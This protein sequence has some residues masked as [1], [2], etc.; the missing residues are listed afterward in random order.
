MLA[1]DENGNEISQTSAEPNESARP[2]RSS[3][4]IALSGMQRLVDDPDLRMSPEEAAGIMGSLWHESGGFK[5]L[6]EIKPVSGRGGFGWAQWTGPRRRQFE[7]FAKANGMDIR[8]D[9]TNFQ[10]LKHELL[11]TPEGK[12]LAPLKRA[13]S[14][15]QASDTFTNVFERPGVPALGS[16]RRNARKILSAW[17]NGGPMSDVPPTDAGMIGFSE[18]QV[19]LPQEPTTDEIRR[20]MPTQVAQPE[21]PPSLLQRGKNLL[22]DAGNAVEDFAYNQVMDPKSVVNNPGQTAKNLGSAAL[23]GVY[24]GSEGVLGTLQAGAE[25][26]NKYLTGPVF[27]AFGVQ[28]P[29]QQL[30][31]TYSKARQGQKTIAERLTPKA[32]S[33]LASGVYS[34]MQSI[35]Q[36]LMTIP[37]AVV[38]GNPLMALAPM[39]VMTGGQSYGEARDA[40]KSPERAALYGTTQGIIEVGTETIPMGKLLGS[41]KAND[42]LWKTF[43]KQ[44]VPE[45]LG[46]QA[47]TF[48]QDLDK[49]VELN[50]DKT[51]KEFMAER[52]SAAIQTA[53]ATLVGTGGQVL[54]GKAADAAAKRW[55]SENKIESLYNKNPMFMEILK[56][57][58]DPS[59]S[60]I[61]RA[62]QARDIM[63][64]R[65]AAAATMPAER[66][67]AEDTSISST[68][69][70]GDTNAQDPAGASTA[71]AEP[72]GTTQAPIQEGQSQ[73]VNAA[74]QAGLDDQ[75]IPPVAG[76]AAEVSPA[77]TVS[78][79]PG[80]A[81]ETV[82][83]GSPT[84]ESVAP[85]NPDQTTDTETVS[86][87]DQGYQLT[88]SASGIDIVSPEGQIHST[89]PD[90]ESALEA[91]EIPTPTTETTNEGQNQKA[92][93]GTSGQEGLLNLPG[94]APGSIPMP[95]GGQVIPGTMENLN[96]N[97]PTTGAG[98]IA[99]GTVAGSALAQGAEGGIAAGVADGRD[100]PASG[101]AG[102]NVGATA[103]AST[104]VN[105]V[106]EPALV[107]QNRNRSNPASVQ[108]M[109][110]IAGNPDYLRLSPSRNFADGAPVIAGGQ[111]PTVQ[112]GRKET[113]VTAKGRRIPVQYAVVEADSVLASNNADGTVN[114]AYGDTAIQAPRAI[115]G[116]GRIAGL[117]K[118][119][120]QGSAGQY[121]ADLAADDLH[122]ISPDIIKGMKAPVLVRVMPESE[123]TQ[124]IGDESNI[125]GGL[126]LSP[127]EQARN[128]AARLDLEG[129]DFDE[130]GTLGRAS[131][132]QFV[133]S[134]PESE[135]GGLL[136][137]DGTP[138]RQAHDRLNSAVF[139]KAYENDELVRL[140]TQ[141]VDPD[142]KLV[143]ST[144]SR[145]APKYS[146]LK[147][148]GLFDVRGWLTDAAK[149]IVNGRRRN[150]TMQQIADQQD[151]DIDP[152]A[153]DIIRLFADNPRSN[154]AVIEDLSDF[155]DFAYNEATR[156]TQ[157]MFGETPRAT[158]NDLR[159]RLEN[160]RE[161]RGQKDLAK[162]SRD[163]SVSQRAEEAAA[164]AAGPN[165][166][167]ETAGGEQG[168]FAGPTA[169]D[170]ARADREALA[171]A[172]KEQQRK[173]NA[174]QAP[175]ADDGL[176]AQDNRQDQLKFSLRPD[177]QQQRIRKLNRGIDAQN[178]RYAGGSESDARSRVEL[179]AAEDVPAARRI[180]W[181]LASAIAAVFKHNL[182]PVRG[183]NGGRL[184]FDAVVDPNGDPSSIFITVDSVSP[185]S[186]VVAHELLHGLRLNAPK[187]Y[188]NLVK[189]LRQLYDA[190]AL[191]DYVN[192]RDYAGELT[193]ANEEE[194]VADFVSNV[195]NS[196]DGLVRV[197][198]AMNRNKAGSGF[199][200]LRRVQGLV[201]RIKQGLA[202]T[203]LGANKV[204]AKSDLQK[205]EDAVVEAL[206]QYAAYQE[207][208]TQPSGKVRFSNRSKDQSGLDAN[209][210]N[211]WKGLAGAFYQYANAD[212]AL[213]FG[214]SDAKDIETVAK[215][216]GR[217]QVEAVDT[218]LNKFD[219]YV[220]GNK[221]AS[222][223][224]NPLQ[225]V[226]E[227]NTAQARS[228]G[229]GKAAMAVAFE[230]AHNNDYRVVPNGGLTTI[231]TFRWTESML[232]AAL[233]HGTT[234]HMRPVAEQKIRGWKQGDDIHNTGLLL[235]RS[236]ANV[237]E[238]IPS[239]EGAVFDLRSSQV[240]LPDGKAF[241]DEEINSRLGA[242]ARAR[243]RGIGLATAKK[244]LVIKAG[245]QG[246]QDPGRLAVLLVSPDEIASPRGLLYSNRQKA[247]KPAFSDSLVTLH[248]LTEENL[249]QA[250][251]IGG[252]PAPSL[253]ITKA[254]SPFTGFGEITLIGDRGLIDP[255][256]GT[257]VFDRDAWTSR[258]PE[259]KFKKIK[260]SKADAL[261]ERMKPARSM[262]DD[263][264][265]FTSD[266]FDRLRNDRNPSPDRVAEPFTRYLAP[267]MLYARDVLG[268][269]IKIPTRDYSPT[270]SVSAD[271]DVLAFYKANEDVIY[272]Q[273]DTS[274]ED[275]QKARDELARL[276]GQAIDRIAAGKSRPAAH[277]EA[278]RLNFFSENG[279]I[280]G[281]GLQVLGRDAP[282]IGTRIEDTIRLTKSIQKV[283][284]DNDPT[285]L[286]WVKEQ[287]SAL[288]DAPTITLRGRQVP[289]TLDNL[290]AAM[291]IG[292]TQGA[293]K[294][295]TFGSGKT[296]AHLGKQFQSIAEI[297]AARS[298]VVSEEEEADGR[299]LAQ[300]VLENYQQHV[301]QFYGGKDYRGQIDTWAGLNDAMEAL[302]KAGKLAD[303]DGNIRLSLQKKGFRKV[304]A[305]AISLARQAIKSLRDVTTNYF[306]AKPQRAVKLN[307]FSGAVAPKSLSPD[308]LEIL[309][310]NGLKVELYGKGDGAR[311]KAIAKLS[312]S[313][314]KTRGDVLFSNRPKQT[315]TPEFK[316]WFAGSKVVDENGDPLVVYHGSFKGADFNV[317]K[318]SKNGVV[319]RGIYL[320]PFNGN[321]LQYGESLYTLYAKVENPLI[322][323][324]ADIP[325]GVDMRARAEALGRDGIIVKSKMR[326]EEISELTVF[327]PNQIKSATDN[328][329]AFDPENDS[330]IQEP[331]QDD[332]FRKQLDIFLDSDPA[333]QPG[334]KTQA[335]RNAAVDAVDAL[336]GS[337]TVLGARL[338][339]TYAARQR[340]SLVG[341]T[342]T[343]R[344][345]LATLAQ[346]YRD[347]RFE[348]FRLFFTNQEGKI[349][350]QVGLTSRLPASSAV[351]VG[352]DTKKFMTDLAEA[353]SKA[354]ATHYYMLHNHPSTNP[355]PSDADV[356]MTQ[357]FDRELN[358]IS[359]GHVVID[360]NQFGFIKPSGDVE[361]IKKDFGQVSPYT[362]NEFSDT[363]ILNPESLIE[364]AKK[365]DV[366]QD[367]ITLVVTT[368]QNKVLGV[369][370]VPADTIRSG[371]RALRG[372]RIRKILKSMSGA[373][374]FA[375]GTHRPTLVLISNLVMD[376][377][378]I[379]ESGQYNS[380]VK[381][382]GAYGQAD[383]FEIRGRQIPRVTADTSPEFDY[384]RDQTLMARGGGM[385]SALNI[386][387]PKFSNRPNPTFYSQLARGFESSRMNSMP[388]SQW[389]AWLFSNKA[390]LGI[391][392]DE[393]AWT[394]IEDYLTLNAKEKLTKADIASYLADNGVRVEEVM[395]EEGDWAV[396]DGEDNQY[397]SSRSEAE[398]YAREIG[399]NIT[400][401]T[402][403]RGANRSGGYGTKFSTYTIPGGTNYRELLITLPT[404]QSGA[405]TEENVKPAQ[406]D[407][408]GGQPD[409]FWYFTVP[410]NF[411]QIRKSKY[412]NQADAKAYI[413]RE[414]QPEPT[415]DKTY[416]SSH[417][418]EKNVLAHIR[419]DERTDADGN[420]VMFITEL[421][422]DWGQEGKKKG[423]A[424]VRDFERKVAAFN[425]ALSAVGLRAEVS[426]QG[427]ATYFDSRGNRVWPSDMTPEEVAVVNAAESIRPTSSSIPAAPFVTDTKSWL[428]LGLKR[429][430]RYAAENGFDKIAFANG[431]QNADLYDL[432]KQV[433][434]IAVPMVNDDGSRSVRIDPEN[435]TAIKLMVDKSGV[436]DGVGPSSEQFTGKT[437]DDVVGKEIADRILSAKE[438][439]TFS[440]EGLKVGGE[441]MRKFY[442]QI[443]PQTANDVLKK[444]GG[445]RVGQVKIGGVT[446]EILDSV[447]QTDYDANYDDLS[448]R[449][450]RN[451]MAA[452]Q[453]KSKAQ[454][455]SQ[456]G[457]DITPALQ[458]KALDGMPLFSNRRNVINQ[459]ALA[460]WTT[461]DDSK[462]DNYV[463][464][465][466]DK[467]IDTKRIVEKL[468]SRVSDAWD[469]YLKETLYHGR[470]A[471]DVDDF[472]VNEIKPLLQAM[473]TRGITIGELETFLHNRHAKEANEQIARIN[474][475]YPDGGSGILTQDAQD[476]L[477][478]L[479]AGKR[480]DLE[481]MAAQI[482][483]IT[484]GTRR[485]LVESGLETQDTIDAWEATYADYVPLQRES[486][487]VLNRG[488][489][490]GQG[491]STKGPASKRRTG[492][493]KA[494][495]D[496]MANVMM[497][498]ERAITRAEKNKVG[499]ALY[500]LAIQNP[501]PEFWYPVNPDAVKKPASVAQELI[502][503]GMLESDLAGLI[504]EPTVASVNPR[505]GLVEYKINPALRNRDNVLAVR[506]KGKD[507][508]L[509]FSTENERAVRMAQS[510]K[511]LDAPE[512]HG[513][514]NAFRYITR[515]VS[516]INTQYN[517]I[518]GVVNLLRDTHGAMLNLSTTPIAGKQAE[519][520]AKIA[521]AMAGIY[522]DLRA[523]RK[524][525]P[526]KGSQ[527]SQLWEEF[528]TVG[529]KTGYRD[530]YATADD[531]MK[532]LEKE[533][534]AIQDG[535]VKRLTRGLFDWL[536]DYNETLE[537]AVR[538]SAYKVGTESGMSKEQAAV[539]AKELTVNF[540]RKGQIA[541]QAGSLYAFFNAAVQG[542]ARLAETVK[543]PAGKKIVAG[544]LLM[545]VIQAM[546]M[547]AAGYD[548]DEPPE[549]L[550]ERNFIIPMPN[551]RYV[552]IPMPL[553]FHVLP[554]TGR[555]LTEI[556]INPDGAGKKIA[557]LLGS[558]FEA[559]NP[560]G[561]AGWSVQTIA[562]TFADPLVALSE[563]RDAFGKEIAKKDRSSTSPTPGF[564]RTKDTA[565]WLSKQ[566]AWG[567]N[568][569][570]GGTD[571]TQG[572]LS[573]TPDQLDYVFSQATGGV[574]R[575]VMKIEQAASA[576]MTGEELP[577]YK[578]PLGV[579]R[580]IGDVKSQSAES[581]RFYANLTRL[582]ELEN[583][584]KGRA[585]DGKDVAG[586]L[587]SNPLATLVP[588][589]N[590]MERA[591]SELRS[592]KRKLI[593]QNAPKATIKALEGQ[594]A[595]Q[596][597]VLNDRV[598]AVAR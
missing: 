445:G 507:R 280:S 107:L 248:N 473:S 179:A 424:D 137:S 383:P 390:K 561:S 332:L 214:R 277:K 45:M 465:L 178:R 382:I 148:K 160:Y 306:E 154:K 497:Q 162:R 290:V 42:A 171:E 70:P 396:Y 429:A 566:L 581:N 421:Q 119:Y 560:I 342:L 29:V 454:S 95:A 221:V 38:T 564:T 482:D 532:A 173:S 261:Y 515:Y 528:Q 335:A 303:T 237:I 152:Q 535:K 97:D 559:F 393:I 533:L 93:A 140:H 537:N 526:R 351:I 438:P 196:P 305:E 358:L 419:F 341:H 407:P 229:S 28:D 79:V 63:A 139:Q 180:E 278:M 520:A 529:G 150:L 234:E 87:K 487:D 319:G 356:R 145:L 157:D 166:A 590:Q 439:T 226:A 328:T 480:T 477:A 285:Y 428:S 72:T 202:G 307:E 544:G 161:R 510:L 379:D 130:D 562:P 410:G 539:M 15:E 177:E 591:V 1:F 103:T 266:L 17:S 409:L 282:K 136:D 118:A 68:G 7:Q 434:S 235:A 444:L 488:M 48:L 415:P 502:N 227:V 586:F 233:R 155:A 355:M 26:T 571:Y 89:Y 302:A 334:P 362:A 55:S 370:T 579:G 492:S 188:D 455:M 542:T 144:L 464:L 181:K 289:P 592:R 417:W 498:R 85:G 314:E 395:K 275:G 81:V 13:R 425:A 213:Q 113:T 523:D 380:L 238:A 423:F 312:K 263:G 408:R 211:T 138:N 453:D 204:I 276:I 225:K 336:R 151:L 296:S 568:R 491:F 220:Q 239:L 367:A 12:V 483:A 293:E 470:A 472:K 201:E 377:L 549:F 511:N 191:V 524:G 132:L 283:V 158:Q 184:N 58:T 357:L 269:P 74:A 462:L 272:G 541:S 255:E 197:A 120:R 412:P 30:A 62:K 218:K 301:V 23:S 343:S 281:R 206:A 241:T 168:L 116:N 500:G 3:M 527:W 165:N 69:I 400:E 518:F 486:E 294:S 208:G 98:G 78:T 200:F 490:T 484:A 190:D 236:Y 570:T 580:F 595:T 279:E 373:R 66:D 594:I 398:A 250:N 244:A 475:A 246:L 159:K 508:F 405:Y 25:A 413:I 104:A 384:L 443:V 565:S 143:M 404:D 321:A 11:N 163:K 471:K 509:F 436:V 469:P 174:T 503:N 291:T 8:D 534:K 344:E 548:D 387:E 14:A 258:F 35:T 133:R 451:V 468:G 43:T 352:T 386:S 460:T 52:P 256:S 495:V 433:K 46:E 135:Q 378:Y 65:L 449:A 575:E 189:S 141:A 574:G 551:G 102:G 536:S 287:V 450:Q 77:P 576:W 555:V 219:L 530:M 298:Q 494:V 588:A 521:P 115:A 217:G 106:S 264:A 456:P 346:V 543:G 212:G 399:V 538:L 205:A 337:G 21:Q 333:G 292:A 375:V 198:F 40:G 310:S 368:A 216:L 270:S 224:L 546:I 16:R 403:F 371:S 516:S 589:G 108:Q 354:G 372:L 80:A 57:E 99:P 550:R 504:Q 598:K 467:H 485:L 326:E 582:N 563:N 420:K 376:S 397:F 540:N 552:S 124:D 86:L 10:F 6:Q 369:T 91:Y 117:Q 176:F 175:P 437:L 265:A 406:D 186:R 20:S 361:I 127:V 82:L 100:R 44:L 64:Q 33:D 260:A 431:Q 479:P 114:A 427:G 353:A 363:A 388:G 271:P 402:V 9:E 349:V 432:S 121:Q 458:D 134:M 53:V 284:P 254:S 583:E 463:Y 329:G 493:G 308:S 199:N 242:D 506:I 142:A 318:E 430:I 446:K 128:D 76:N 215:E 316:R 222:M 300:K 522:G 56:T 330:I 474:P 125:A 109:Q 466:Q 416:R 339:D 554:N 391:K 170:R 230:W 183:E 365:L 578:Y 340:V 389:R 435:G 288:F 111:I 317:F 556:A 322:I 422:S 309:E 481:A 123:L 182:I 129:L 331:L 457:F 441:G 525:K 315:E 459:P 585:K 247:T 311:E 359:N 24:R 96:A 156:D 348:T 2:K 90:I 297:Q 501:N 295:M 573:P 193:D 512:M 203:P 364:V 37:A 496:I 31:Q 514:L 262:G 499:L 122:G 569:I 557:G 374:V 5:Q 325:M 169:E 259:F 323:E 596:M 60:G 360:T 18:E 313:L 110:S 587:R 411:L 39:G 84:Q 327:S 553:G 61:E 324:Y 185:I 505:T 49:W 597:K 489:G 401:D 22:T 267:K 426:P 249:A 34:G 251:A 519:V 245:L 88:E 36:N 149:A 146:R 418:D 513:L 240:V 345:D 50:P 4:D 209:D 572:A 545:G 223:L 461:P 59:L 54:L 252:L 448:D 164:D 131:V 253:G 476:Y 231:N 243:Q 41:I 273:R 593:A 414:K 195:I 478:N 517:P 92:N 32:D 257:P 547:A 71:P 112:M 126:S 366:D 558:F 75:P 187:I 268:K 440:G 338:A 286:K 567:L 350:S 153:Y 67:Q 94:Q 167:Q 232:S 101:P 304:D 194:W 210:I 385:G 577:P 531:R 394:G 83:A 452:A 105:P 172:Q 347:T 320:T 274:K 51:A 147:D 192:S 447:A 584:I 27:N 392:D 442:D 73:A 381:Q 47:A 228:D 207:K 19:I 299:R